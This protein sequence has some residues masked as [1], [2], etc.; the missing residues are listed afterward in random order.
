MRTGMGIKAFHLSG[1]LRGQGHA[2]A[3]PGRDRP[4]AA[5]GSP[6]IGGHALQPHELQ[7]AARELEVVA[8][9]Q[10]RQE[11]LFHRAQASS[12]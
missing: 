5:L 11:A 6:H 1:Q 4:V 2:P 12:P 9:A 10:A 7:R 3:L 8:R